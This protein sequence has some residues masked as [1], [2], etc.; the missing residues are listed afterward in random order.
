MH[1][2]WRL[3]ISI[4][5][6]IIYH[7]QTLTSHNCWFNKLYE[8]FR[9]LVNK[10]ELMFDVGGHFVYTLR[11]RDITEWNCF[12][13]CVRILCITIERTSSITDRNNVSPIVWSLAAVATSNAMMY[14]PNIQLSFCVVAFWVPEINVF[15]IPN[16]V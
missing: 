16:E 15:R 9:T 4:K 11:N 8:Q 6:N 14:D 10:D 5:L 13:R 7:H 12:D 1:L 3:N 2:I